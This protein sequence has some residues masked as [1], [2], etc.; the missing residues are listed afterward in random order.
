VEV[1][2]WGGRPSQGNRPAQKGWTVW[3][4][5]VKSG[6]PILVHGQVKIDQ[7]DD[8]NPRAEIVATEIELLSAV[9]SHKTREL[10]LR[11]DADGLTGNR[12]TSLKGLLAKHPGNCAVTIR[13]VIPRESETTVR[14]P[15]KV[16]PS[17]D[18]IESA[19]RLGFE[20]ELR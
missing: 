13:A 12:A 3:E 2:C 6:E 19:R 4:S 1:I 11:I 14:I 18:L 8:E 5:V 16:K 20:V 15:H 10:A 7:R 17:D 9:R